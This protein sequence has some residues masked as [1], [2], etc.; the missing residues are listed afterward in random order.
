MDEGFAEIDKVIAEDPQSYAGLGLAA[1]FYEQLKK[2]DQAILLREKM[3]LLDP[4]GAQN[5]LT[6]G[7]DYLAIGNKEKALEMGKKIVD[8]SSRVVI[9]PKASY[10]SILQAAHAEL[11]A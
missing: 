4:W 1:S 11:G 9:D 8:I 5:Y 2:F 6:L 10:P 7:R 3:A